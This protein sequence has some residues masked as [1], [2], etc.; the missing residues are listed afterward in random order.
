M[1]HTFRTK[2]TEEIYRKYKENIPIDC[3]CVLCALPS[4]RD[5]KYWRIVKNDFPYDLIAETHDMILPIRHV[6]ET[7][8]T[9][10]EKTE[11]LEIKA[12]Y[13]NIYDAIL[14]ATV[15]MKTVPAHHH[16]H[17]IVTKDIASS[18]CLY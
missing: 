16:L 1:S 6:K 15:R 8:L 9:E 3:K 10:E 4:I 5:F 2:E 13:L 12:D 14:E 7:E 18:L 17:V 11:L